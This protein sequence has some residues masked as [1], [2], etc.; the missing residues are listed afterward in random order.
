[1][2]NMNYLAVRS[3]DDLDNLTPGDNCTVCEIFPDASQTTEFWNRWD[4]IS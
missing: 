1:M 4:R 2:W 3:L